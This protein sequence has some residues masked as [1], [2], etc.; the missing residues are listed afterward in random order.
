MSEMCWLLSVFDKD[1]GEFEIVLN[2]LCVPTHIASAHGNTS[3]RRCCSSSACVS[4]GSCAAGVPVIAFA[5]VVVLSAN[6]HTNPDGFGAAPGGHGGSPGAP[7]AANGTHRTGTR[8]PTTNRLIPS[9]FGR[10]VWESC[11]VGAYAGAVELP[12]RLA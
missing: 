10:S 1:G 3:P 9:H 8:A 7:R 11:Q 5:D 2:E 6:T 12:R 4:H